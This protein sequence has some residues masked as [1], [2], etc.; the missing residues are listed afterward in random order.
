MMQVRRKARCAR[1]VGA[2]A[3]LVIV[4]KILLEELIK[5]LLGA[6]SPGIHVDLRP[7]A[8]SG[9]VGVR[10]QSAS[11]SDGGHLAG[12]RKVRGCAGSLAALSAAK[13]ARANG[14]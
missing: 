10:F 11:L 7:S 12:A 8:Q 6:L 4:R 3:T 5:P 1:E 13:A 9:F 2:I 14:V